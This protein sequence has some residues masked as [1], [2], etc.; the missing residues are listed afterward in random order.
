MQPLSRARGVLCTAAVLGL[1]CN[2]ATAATFDGTL[3]DSAKSNPP[4]SSKVPAWKPKGTTTRG[5]PHVA[6]YEGWSFRAPKGWKMTVRDD[7]VFLVRRH[8]GIIAVGTEATTD[9][10]RLTQGLASALANLGAFPPPRPLGSVSLKATRV[11]YTEV[12]GRTQQG[13]AAQVR[14]VGLVGQRGTV[15]VIG[16]SKP[17]QFAAVRR[18]VD[19]TARSVR[20]FR[21][22]VSPG[23]RFVMGEWWSYTGT[24]TW[25]GGGGSSKS[26]AFC[27]DGRFFTDGE[28][29]Y[30]GKAGTSEAW[31]VASQGGDAGRW[32]AVG[33]KNSGR[34]TITYRNGNTAEI[35]YRAKP[36]SDGVYF[37][38]RVYG[39]TGSQ[40]YCR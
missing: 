4:S 12:Q 25:D 11:L 3:V 15:M 30:S 20:S 22:R 31:G 27:P 39:R 29:S 35:P 23:R 6:P 18:L 36:G 21:P 34:I 17:A 13:E 19:A 16:L 2:D 26:L 32:R 37:D 24:S 14:A 40:K 33:D 9:P 10:A 38:G 5:K 7:A 28:A 8:V 1:L